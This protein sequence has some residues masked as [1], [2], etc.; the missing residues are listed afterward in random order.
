M[1]C[2]DVLRQ[3]CTIRRQ[4]TTSMFQSLIIAL[5]LPHLDYCNSA[6]YGLPTSL[7][8]CLHFVQNAAARLIFGI[9]HSENRTPALTDL[10]WLRVHAWAHFLLIYRAIHGAAPRYLQSCFTRVADMPLRRRLRS[11]C[12]DR[13][14]VPL[15]RLST[16]GSRTFPV[17]GAVVGTTCHLMSHL[18]HRWRF[19]DSA[20]RH[21]CSRILFL[22][23]SFNSQTICFSYLRGLRDNCVIYATLKNDMMMM[24]MTMLRQLVSTININTSWRSHCT[25]HAAECKLTLHRYGQVHFSC[26]PQTA[27]RWRVV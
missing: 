21:F 6:L 10:H 1:A 24:M 17:S 2:G 9:R 12:S 5:V 23:L 3:L 16:V 7:I 26:D 15:I 13:L 27:F 18:R 19:S 25:V 8:R 14:H 20:L 11:S 22:A 4:V